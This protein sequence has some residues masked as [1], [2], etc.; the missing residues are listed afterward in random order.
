[1]VHGGAA[2]RSRAARSTIG[3]RRASSAALSTPSDAL[4][5][6]YARPLRAQGVAGNAT[7]LDENVV[8]AGSTGAVGRPEIPTARLRRY[9]VRM[10]AA[11]AAP[12]GAA[13]TTSA[14]LEPRPASRRALRTSG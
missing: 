3:D 5:W 12:P 11:R 9:R 7:P 8:L 13:R 4:P 10:Q 6:R 2:R 1:M 14:L